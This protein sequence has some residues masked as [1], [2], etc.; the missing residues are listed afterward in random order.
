MGNVFYFRLPR[1]SL[2]ERFYL[3]NSGITVNSVFLKV[4][5][6]SAKG[7][8]ANKLWLLLSL[9]FCGGLSASMR[10]LHLLS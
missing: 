5:P 9:Q 8:A 6:F 10:L 1:F 7:E 4:N 2:Y 3:G